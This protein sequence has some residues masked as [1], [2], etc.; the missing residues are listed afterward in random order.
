MQVRS[1]LSTGRSFVPDR[2][3]VIP[4]RWSLLRPLKDALSVPLLANGDIFT[5]DD[6][7]SHVAVVF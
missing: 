3:N 6:V 1:H 4:A 5:A 7:V 2:S